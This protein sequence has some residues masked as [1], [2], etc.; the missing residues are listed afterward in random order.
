M[1]HYI[2]G[3]FARLKKEE[4]VAIVICRHTRILHSAYHTAGHWIASIATENLGLSLTP[5][6]GY[7]YPDGAYV[8]FDGDK[9]EIAENILERIHFAMAIDRQAHLKIAAEIISADDTTKLNQAMLPE[10]FRPNPN[11]PLRLVTIEG[12]KSVPCGGTHL[13]G[14]REIKSL[15]AT[16]IFWKNGKIRISY[17]CT[18]WEMPVS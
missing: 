13:S 17:H 18:P 5:I 8:E 11:K 6:K 2:S 7:H 3:N 14:I 4:K 1:K 15:Q 16:K 9:S 12:Y 10:N